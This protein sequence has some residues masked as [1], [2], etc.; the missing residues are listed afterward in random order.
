MVLEQPVVEDLVAI[1]Q[2]GKERVARQVVG[3]SEVLLIRTF[4]LFLER[5]HGLRKQPFEPER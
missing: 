5:K 2:R 3:L 4:R 1:V